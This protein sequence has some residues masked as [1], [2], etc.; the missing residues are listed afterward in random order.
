LVD[1]QR[2]DETQ[3][4]VDKGVWSILHNGGKGGRGI[5]WKIAGEESD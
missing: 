2:D 1:L 5:D 3:G 4:I